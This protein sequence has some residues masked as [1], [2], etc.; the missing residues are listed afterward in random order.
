MSYSDMDKRLQKRFVKVTLKVMHVS[1]RTQ[2]R[3]LT[4]WMVPPTKNL[5]V[6]GVGR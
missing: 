6:A 5:S 3:T 1:V 2:L 4:R